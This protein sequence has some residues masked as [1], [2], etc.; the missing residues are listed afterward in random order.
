M[1]IEKAIKRIAILGAGP[2]G[3]F[4]FKR[5]VEANQSDWEIDI[6][7]KNSQLGAGMPYSQEG[8][9]DE[10]VTNVSGKEVPALVSSLED[11]VQTLP[12]AT[13]DRFNIDPRVFNEYKV[14]PRLLFG[15]YLAAQFDLLLEQANR[16]G[17][18]TR[19]H[20]SS[21]IK[22]I[23]D[24]PERRKVLVTVDKIGVVAF[25]QVILCTGHHWP[26]KH[27][28]TVR[29][30]FDSPY[31]PAK[32][33]LPLNHAVAIRGSSLTA[34]D[35]IRTLSRS[36]GAF[37]AQPD[38]TLSF[39][40]DPG[41]PHF[42]L[43]IHSRGGFLPA[44]RFHLEESL[45]S[46]DALLT[47]E[48]IAAER[49]RNEGFLPLDYVF[50]KNFKDALRQKDPGFYEQIKA[51]NLED[52]VD[53]MMDPRERLEA[54]ELFKVEYREAEQSIRRQ[55]SIYWKEILAELSYTMNYPAKYFS[56]EDMLRLQKV[57]MPLISIVI[58]FVPQRSAQELL[59]LHQAGL[60]HIISVGS[61]SEVKPEKNG[62]ATIQYTDDANQPQATYYQTFVD[63]IGQPHLS[64]EEFPF[65]G[66]I[67]T[68]SISPARLRFRSAQQGKIE[69]TES[70]NR[71]EQGPRGDYYLNVPG[72]AITD[73]FQVVGADQVANPRIYMMAVPYMGGYNPD[74][75]GLDFCETASERIVNHLLDLQGAPVLVDRKS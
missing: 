27:E 9:N 2:S 75:S 6:F 56:A 17:I 47:S 51:M 38:G 53:R 42:K 73:T 49:A 52:F 3:L 65:K 68:G 60:L 54:F 28:G 31:P 44:I 1:D 24:Q 43:V 62:G 19:V 33:V 18:T 15:Q 21:A 8:A 59:A 34:I 20:F 35:A 29:N 48:E 4:M 67:A 61:D 72:I 16:L 23:T 5:L 22:D 32:L 66:L 14:V 63:C 40:T 69:S 36:N 30:Y 11:W 58:A 13:L 41:S 7:D 39:Q 25:D 12:E 46:Q 55:E 50:E 26:K 10:H 37:T 57:L 70:R 71:I 74:Y 45:L 64:F